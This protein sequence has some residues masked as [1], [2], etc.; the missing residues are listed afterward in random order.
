MDST[1]EPETEKKETKEP[2]KEQDTSM[3]KKAIF[4]SCEK[5]A[6]Q[7]KLYFA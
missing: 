2:N 5:R 3:G 6:F 4:M 7:N 1:R